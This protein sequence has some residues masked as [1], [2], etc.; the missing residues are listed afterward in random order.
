MTFLGKQGRCQRSVLASVLEVGGER[1]HNARER[2][3]FGAA[4]GGD[5]VLDGFGHPL[6]DVVLV[7]LHLEAHRRE[8]STVYHRATSAG[9]IAMSSLITRDETLPPTY[10]QALESCSLPPLW[11]ALHVLL[12]RERTT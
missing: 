1:V 8:S 7:N 9:R 10:S 12:P 4:G 5:F 3:A 6:A 11:T 2:F